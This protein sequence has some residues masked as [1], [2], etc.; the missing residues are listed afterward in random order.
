MTPSTCGRG[1]RGS[2]LARRRAG[3][4]GASSTTASSSPPRTASATTPRGDPRSSS[5]GEIVTVCMWRAGHCTTSNWHEFLCLQNLYISREHAKSSEVREKVLVFIG[6]GHLGGEDVGMEFRGAEIHI[7]PVRMKEV[8]CFK[9][10]T[11]IISIFRLFLVI[12]RKLNESNK[13]TQNRL[14]NVTG[15]RWRQRNSK[16]Q[17]HL[18]SLL[19]QLNNGVIFTWKC[20]REHSRTQITKFQIRPICRPL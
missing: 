3:A 20:K 12:K 11:E 13:S 18:L 17:P 16:K 1:W 14:K 2:R 6:G 10:K 9:I 5:A 7:H 15:G 19:L 8:F 4:A